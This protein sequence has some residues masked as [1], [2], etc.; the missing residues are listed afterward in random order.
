MLSLFKPKAWFAGILILI[1]GTACIAWQTHAAPVN[2]DAPQQDTIPTREKKLR[3]NKDQTIITGDLDKTMEQFDRA[4]EN[5][6]NQLQ[7]TDWQKAQEALRESL[8]KINTEKIEKQMEAALRNIDAQK[9]QMEIQAELKKIDWEKMQQEMQKALAEVKNNV[10]F[11]K[12]EIELQK[13]LEESKSAM[14]EMQ[15]IDREKMNEELEKTGLMLKETMGKDF[16][17][18]MEKAKEGM[19]H[20]KEELRNY[21]EMLTDMEKDGLLSTKENY[22]V[23]YKN[24]DLFING[25]KQ[26]AAVADKYK[27]YFKKAH[28]TTKKEKDDG[29][30]DKIID[31]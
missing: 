28:V 6:N 2:K 29:D 10:D 1:A 20:A 23:E 26:P 22:K 27:H 15:H 25:K 7:N 21:K 8:Q 30:D 3:P 18:E 24:G 16:K 11:K 4:M 9:I 13:A 19:N 12:G 5:L 31:L 17:K 14:N